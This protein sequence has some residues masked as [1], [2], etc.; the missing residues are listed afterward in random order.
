MSR[1][2]TDEL[3]S[4]FLFEHLSETQLAW[5]AERSE[6]LAFDAG[7]S[8]YRPGDPAR[9]LYVLLDGAI[10]MTRPVNGEDVVTHETGH[11]GA[12][13]G[14]TRAWAQEEDPV[15]VGGV[16][17]TAA[18][19]LVCL[20]AEEFSTFMH[21]HFPLAIHML[22]GLYL[23]VR[24]AEATIQ[25]REHLA[26][27][28]TLSANLAHELNNPAA[29][30]VRATGQLR[31]RV[32]GMRSKLAMI[33]GGQMS[34]TTLAR[35]VRVQEEAVERAA[36]GRG[37]IRTPLEEADLEDALT[38]HLDGLG[39]QAAYDLAP[40][41]AAAGLDVAWVDAVARDAGD[42]PL[43]GAL[44]WLAYTLETES[45][46][47][48]IEDATGRISTLVA[49][50]KQYSYVDSASVQEVDVHVGLDSTVVML[51]HKL[52]SV[53]VGR[54]YDRNLPKVPVHAAELNQVWTNLI[55]NAADAMGGA[56]TLTLRTRAE[57]EELVVEVADDG[58]GIP[59]GVRER[60]FEAFFTTKPPGDGS[61]LG[62]DTARRIV[63]NRHHGTIDLA[64]GPDG[65]CFQV[66]L[67]LRQSLA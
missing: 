9:H 53:R 47:D 8:V 27:L 39:V 25:Q 1:A 24:N 26:R 54:D 40:V 13:F 36:K 59:A 18:T 31:G 6:H 30:A 23:G 15:Y 37:S 41:F 19:R 49:A 66:R 60:V 16:R 33:A 57:G 29:A 21:E 28:G 51:S 63:V 56:G 65:T 52:R 67:P 38:D 22:D 11:R 55:D 12:Y 46:M 3:R 62:L 14:A 58:P 17:T 35:L 42:E 48:E 2:S 20:P 50:V 43:D 10:R 61:G 34:P 7:A 44:R 64:T 32:A 45:L 4:L 5:L